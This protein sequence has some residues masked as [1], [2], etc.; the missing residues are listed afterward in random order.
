R[1]PHKLR[2]AL[3]GPVFAWHIPP[4]EKVVADAGAVFERAVLHDVQHFIGG[5][6]PLRA[7][8]L[9]MFGEVEPVGC[10]VHAQLLVMVVSVVEA[11]YSIIGKQTVVCKPLN[12]KNTGLSVGGVRAPG[13]AP[14]A[15]RHYAV[16]SGLDVSRAAGRPR[17]RSRPARRLAPR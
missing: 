4:A 12:M 11:L 7:A 17:R 9:G 14:G 8:D 6:V 5:D 2:D 1:S 13:T 16:R 3:V 10:G 15:S